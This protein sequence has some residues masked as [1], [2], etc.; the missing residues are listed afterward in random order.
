[1]WGILDNAFRFTC[2]LRKCPKVS[3]LTRLLVPTLCLLITKRLCWH[4][5][6][7]GPGKKKGSWGK[8]KKVK[9][10]TFFLF[11]L[12]FCWNNSLRKDATLAPVIQQPTQPTNGRVRK[13][14]F[15]QTS[16]QLRTVRFVGIYPCSSV[17][18]HPFTL[19]L[20]HSL[21]HAI[22]YGCSS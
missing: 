20:T 13:S 1:M 11:F 19:P 9:L 12:F 14:L 2:C 5:S 17:I 21:T 18:T 10:S 7:A 22:V 4:H 3:S 16:L 6:E 8:N 15:H